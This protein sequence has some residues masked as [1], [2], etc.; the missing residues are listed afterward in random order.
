MILKA[1]RGEKL[2]VYG[3]G[4]NRRDWIYVGDHVRGLVLALARGRVGETYN[5][6]GNCEMRNTDVVRAIVDAVNLECPDLHR[7]AGELI[8][9]V[10]DRP[11]HD[12]RYAID[13]AKAASE[14]GWRPSQTF[15]TGLRKSVRWYLDHAPWVGEIESGNYRMERLG[16]G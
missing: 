9:F 2:P 15:S 8:T 5:F 12:R 13:S 11:G 4:G 14:L 3:D 6:G 7:D 1:V 16:L 10:E